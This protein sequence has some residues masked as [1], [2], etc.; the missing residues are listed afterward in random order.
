[1]EING[2]QVELKIDTGANCNVITL[3]LFKSL[4]GGEEIDESKAVQLIAYGGDTSTLGTVNFECNLKS[5]RRNLELHVVDRQ[6]TPLL[7]LPDSSS[8][9]LIQLHSE[10]HEVDTVDAFRAALLDEYKDLFEGDLG[11]LPVIYK[12]SL[13]PDTTPVGNLS[14]HLKLKRQQQKASYDHHAKPLSPLRP[15]QVVSLGLTK[16]VRK[17]ALLSN[18][19]HSHGPTLCKLAEKSTVEIADISWLFQHLVLRS[20]LLFLNTLLQRPIRMQPIQRSIQVL[21]SPLPRPLP[22]LQ[23]LSNLPQRRLSDLKHQT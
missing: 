2:K 3:D 20:L 17:L 7:G 15:Q 19:L 14:S 13:N 5:R 16:V 1:M 18:S 6:A 21:S 11:N 22:S 8:L 10:V 23:V 4:S 9:N 12:M